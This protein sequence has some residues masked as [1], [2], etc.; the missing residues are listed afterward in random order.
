MLKLQ[1]VDKKTAQYACEHWH[2]SKCIP[3]GKMICF[4]IWED[5]IFKGVIIYSKGANNNQAQ[6]YGLKHNQLVELTRIA[7]NT[8]KIEVSKVIS[9][10][11]R[12]LKKLCPHIKLIFSFADKDQNHKGTIYKASNFIY[13]GDNHGL[14]D[15]FIVKGKKTHRRSLYS[16]LKKYNI[17]VTLSNIQK[18]LDPKATVFKPKGKHLFVYILDKQDTNLKNRII[19]LQNAWLNSES[20]NQ[21]VNGGASP[22]AT[23]HL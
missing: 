15:C 14:T 3:A 8:H 13:L 21:P 6:Y 7:M 16:I 18:Y 17:T 10:S 11:I 20:R 5:D 2:Y 22:T 12:I 1:L 4:G 9:I 23:L 19:E